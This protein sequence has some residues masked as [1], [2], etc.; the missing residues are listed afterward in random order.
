MQP[1]GKEILLYF[2]VRLEKRL[3]F[4]KSRNLSPASHETSSQSVGS[5]QQMQRPTSPSPSLASEQPKGE[6]KL[7]FFFVHLNL[8]E[9]IF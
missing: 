7:F 5:R 1:Q 8:H 9:I 6:N 2:S 3:F 4:S